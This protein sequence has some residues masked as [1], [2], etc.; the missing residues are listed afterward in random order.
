MAK[1]VISH[2]R[3]S[4]SP[5]D[6]RPK[7]GG[8]GGKGTWGGL[9]DT[10]S[11]YPLDSKD[12]NYDS[13]EEL[14]QLLMTYSLLH[15]LNKQRELLPN[16]SKGVEARKELRKVVVEDLAMFLARAVMDEA[17][18]P[19]HLE[20]YAGW[21]VDDVKLKIAKLLEEYESGG[22]IREAY[23]CIKDRH[24]IFPPRGCKESM[25]NVWTTWLSTCL[26]PEAVS[27]IRRESKDNRMVGSSFHYGNSTNGKRMGPAYDNERST[28]IGGL[29]R[30]QVSPSQFEHGRYVTWRMM[31]IEETRDLRGKFSPIQFRAWSV[32]H[33]EDDG[34]RGNQRS[35]FE[36]KH[37]MC[38]A[39]EMSTSELPHCCPIP[40]KR[41]CSLGSKHI[42]PSRTARARPGRWSS[43]LYTDDNLP[44][45]CAVAKKTSA[46]S[47]HCNPV[48]RA[49][50]V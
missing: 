22:D 42:K 24:A 20:E 47:F 49:V 21:A 45:P 15:S 27:S 28:M 35:Q 17:L 1:A 13:S 41:S 48:N 6:G 18:A 14:E 11:S 50:S 43:A 44:F 23:R 29:N 10:D 40:L 8:C 30:G 7:K 3:Q 34:N 36:L 31:E 2:D 25:K 26:M 38:I 39:W 16:D 37:R 19:Q 12:P 4:R 9:M 33:L 32:R 5:I 46:G